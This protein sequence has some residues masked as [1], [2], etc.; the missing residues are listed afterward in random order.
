MTERND[1]LAFSWHSEIARIVGVLNTKRYWGKKLYESQ[2]EFDKAVKT[3][4][5]RYEEEGLEY[6]ACFVPSYTMVKVGDLL[7]YKE[8][9]FEGIKVSVPSNP[10][11]FLK[12]QYGDFSEMPLPHQRI[13][14]G[15]LEF[16]EEDEEE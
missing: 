2:G 9:N 16:G 8:M 12:M 15:L 14:H 10:I 1:K 6:V 11:V 3:Y 7:P 13:G 5:L 4:D